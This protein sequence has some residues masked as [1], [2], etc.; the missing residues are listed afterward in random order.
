VLN[1]IPPS[2]GPE[3]ALGV[4]VGDGNGCPGA[5]VCAVFPAV[6]VFIDPEGEP[7]KGEGSVLLLSGLNGDG[8]GRLGRV[9]SDFFA[10]RS[11]SLSRMLAYEGYRS[12]I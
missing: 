3:G 1:L 9:A 2:P 10:S 8:R 5:V 6:G 11:L 7:A 12:P 4:P